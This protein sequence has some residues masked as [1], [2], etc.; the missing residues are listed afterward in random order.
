M[1]SYLTLPT[2]TLTIA[3]AVAAPRHKTYK[4]QVRPPIPA[5]HEHN[6]QHGR[7]GGIPHH[8][9]L[10][11]AMPCHAMLVARR[12]HTESDQTRPDQTSKAFTTPQTEAKG[13]PTI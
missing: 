10:C 8:T 13:Q 3:I 12:N 9:M 6:A 5:S 11:H 1:F 4:Q 2:T 7:G